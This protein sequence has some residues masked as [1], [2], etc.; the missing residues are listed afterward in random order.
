MLDQ[1]TGDLDAEAH[2]DNL[3]DLD[4]LPCLALYPAGLEDLGEVR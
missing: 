1:A 4:R 3:L 2:L